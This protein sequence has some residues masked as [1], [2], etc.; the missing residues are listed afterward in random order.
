MG[1]RAIRLAGVDGCRGG[2][3]VVEVVVRAGRCCSA[4]ARL[5]PRIEELVA[6]RP[7]VRVIAL[8]MPIGL[9]EE[10]QPGGREC[11]RLARLLLGRPRAS[12]VFSPP[13]RPQLADGLARGRPPVGMSLQTFHLLPKIG[14]VDRALRPSD[15]ARI[16]EA[17]PELAFMAL[18]GRPMRLNKQTPAGRR[19][20]LR[21][22]DRLPPSWRRTL[23][24]ILHGTTAAFA[25]ADVAPDDLLDA[26][27]L[28]WTAWRAYRGDAL[29]LPPNP[30]QDLRGLRMEIVY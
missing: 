4:V 27:V 24:P 29:R 7:D 17:H 21:A 18:A 19:E 16:V 11:D 20:R 8:D 28:S 1:T 26:A 25:R 22:L 15:Q 30:P 3:V 14:E 9:L 12:S 13:S 5:C 23:A 6:S 2:W 10:Q